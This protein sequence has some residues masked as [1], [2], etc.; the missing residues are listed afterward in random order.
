MDKT[1]ITTF[2]DEDCQIIAL[3]K[4]W[5]YQKEVNG[6]MVP[7]DQTP[8]MFVDE[9]INNYLRGLKSI[10][11]FKAIEDKAVAD[12]SSLQLQVKAI[13]DAKKQ[14]LIDAQKIIDAKDF[15]QTVTPVK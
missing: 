11:I 6:S 3:A 4:D 15:T 9:L 10:P 1:Y 14:A 7:N 12:T 2:S 5:S 8:R 13:E